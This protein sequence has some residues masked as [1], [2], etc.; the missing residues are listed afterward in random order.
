MTTSSLLVKYCFDDIIPQELSVLCDYF[1]LN[2]MYNYKK[3]ETIFGVY[4]GMVKLMEISAEEL[5]Q[6]LVNDKLNEFIHDC[7]K[8]RKSGYYNEFC[9]MNIKVGT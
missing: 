8:N 2:N 3:V 7:Y 5:H 6:A 9:K 1:G 4:Q